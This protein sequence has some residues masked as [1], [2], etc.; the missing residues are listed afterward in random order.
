MEEEKQGLYQ[1]ETDQYDDLLD[2][3]SLHSNTS[4]ENMHTVAT[5]EKDDII[6]VVEREERIELVGFSL[7]LNIDRVPSHIDLCDDTD[8][9]I[10]KSLSDLLQDNNCNNVHNNSLLHSDSD[11]K[12]LDDGL[13]RN[14]L[15]S[16][17]EENNSLESST[18]KID[19]SLL[20][21]DAQRK[22]MENLLVDRVKSADDLLKNELQTTPSQT[23]MFY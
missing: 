3:R 11:S 18:D 12:M 9:F 19:T 8:I 15:Q 14:V 4:S 22:S 10:T 13:K 1:I 17:M 20:D 2:G 7:G 6:P 16:T 5:T 21:K 23:N